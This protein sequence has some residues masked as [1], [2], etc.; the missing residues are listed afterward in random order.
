MS[1]V[2]AGNQ[3]LF[4]AIA[5]LIGLVVLA[6]ALVFLVG[7]M[8]EDKPES[9]EKSPAATTTAQAP[10]S[11]QT[12]RS[13]QW[14]F[15]ISY[16]GR[17]AVRDNTQKKHALQSLN[18]ARLYIGTSTPTTRPNDMQITIDTP[19]A[20]DGDIERKCGKDI[21]PINING[22]RRSKCLS[23][24]GLTET[25]D[26]VVKLDNNK[27]EYFL[28][29]NLGDSSTSNKE[30]KQLEKQCDSVFSTFRFVPSS[31]SKSN[32]LDTLFD[33]R[34][35]YTDQLLEKIRAVSEE[36]TNS[37]SDRAP[38]SFTKWD[39]D[40]D[41]QES[42][43]VGHT[44][45]GS[46]NLTGDRD[47]SYE[48]IMFDIDK[49]GNIANPQLVLSQTYSGWDS[50]DDSPMF[51]STFSH[52]GKTVMK[53]QLRPVMNQEIDKDVEYIFYA[54]DKFYRADSREELDEKIFL[55]KIKSQYTEEML[56]DPAFVKEGT[57]VKGGQTYA[58]TSESR[59]PVDFARW[60]HDGDGEESLAVLNNAGNVFE[61]ILFDINERNRISN[62]RRID[63]RGT[64][65]W[66]WRSANL[67]VVS[68]DGDSLLQSEIRLGNSAAHVNY[69]SF[70]N[71]EFI[72]VSSEVT[73]E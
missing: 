59:E 69:Y 67:E 23:V 71:G 16:P 15:E 47:L 50:W 64:A 13:D 27:N 44:F 58:I 14:E 32:T 10:D 38:E 6:T 48:I 19:S 41:G 49:N 56:S 55:A 43:F 29:C 26:Y 40:Q 33:V 37:V 1:Q 61:I 42:L 7:E 24:Y 20:L 52:N 63:D 46:E 2:D 39:H 73:R 5:G 8:S 53:S 11:W 72:D 62:P 65:T 57:S 22:V 34:L 68:E 28:R 4:K 36:Q 70:R 54:N 21:Q 3:S 18:P 25:Q 45:T 9:A 60:D 12:Y 30:R 35:Q 31:G 66:V 51:L 17:F